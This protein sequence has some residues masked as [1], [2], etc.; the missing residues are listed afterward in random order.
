MANKKITA[1]KYEQHGN[2]KECHKDIVS[3]NILYV[4]GIGVFTYNNEYSPNLVEVDLL[5][6]KSAILTA[7]AVVNKGEYT[8]IFHDVEQI[9]VSEAKVNELVSI[10]LESNK[11]REKVKEKAH[12][13]LSK[14]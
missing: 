6:D 8:H 14:I 10:L 4:P 7:E 9:R 11:I 1:Y 5:T 12:S 3:D 2:C 13:L